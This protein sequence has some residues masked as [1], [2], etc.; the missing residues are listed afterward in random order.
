MTDHDQAVGVLA[1]VLGAGDPA[2]PDGYLSESGRILAAL[3]ERGY[4]VSRVGDLD[5]AWA[6]AE[7]VLPEGYAVMLR[8]SN[9]W[10][11]RDPLWFAS[12]YHHDGRRRSWTS[13]DGP[14]PAAALN[15]LAV[16]LSQAGRK[17]PK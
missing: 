6:A 14:T 5:A 12:A 7:A 3:A 9:D 8:G 2:A 1:E 13:A 11:G 15:A 10:M 16:Q 17:E 4:R